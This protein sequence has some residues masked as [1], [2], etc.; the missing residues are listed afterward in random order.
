MVELWHYLLKTKKPIW[1][2]G[3]GDGADKIINVLEKYDIKIT[4]VFAS[5][6]FVRYQNFRGFTVVSYAEAKKISP[7]MIVL[8]CFGTSRSEVLE[9]I[10][11]IAAE[12]ELFA[13]DVPVIGGG[14]YNLNY[15]AE[16]KNELNAVYARLAD[17]QSKKVFENCLNYRLT[18]DISYLKRCE[19]EP[20]EAWENIIKPTDDESFIDLGAF[21][22]DTVEEFL[23]HVNGY[24]HIY[25]VE[26]T[27]K[28]FNRMAAKIGGME[29]VSLFNVAISDKAGELTF[30]TH[31]GRNH[32]E[33]ETG[34]KIK[35]LSVDEILGQK[36]AT[37][38]KMDIE[39][40]EGAA[41][42][43]ARETIL[44][45]KPKMQIAAYHRL[46][47][48]FALPLKIFEIRD[49]YRIYMRHFRSVPAWDTNFYF[50]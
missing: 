32:A 43:G 50:V 24:G 4:G 22:G 12:Q 29:K 3:M 34:E 1:L 40:G 27:A 20:E 11:R 23:S 41:I 10:D 14:Y 46:E 38:I 17:E 49:D 6:Q 9:N 5:D 26:P 16:H 2:Y 7:E 30:N 42:D 33:A 21:C 8:V 13:P 47:D 18:G 15:A 25:A 28:S 39:G 31:G 35:S 36:A 19:T 45:F 37:F 48:Y 44:R